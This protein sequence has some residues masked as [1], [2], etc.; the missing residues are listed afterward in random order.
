M[1]MLQEKLIG[2]VAEITCINK[3]KIQLETNLKDQLGVDSTEMV[4]IASKVE[5][6]LSISIDENI[7]SKWHT[8]LAIYDYVNL[9]RVS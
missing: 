7:F 5:K 3:D 4:E 6:D 8:I 1:N 9:R 2:Y